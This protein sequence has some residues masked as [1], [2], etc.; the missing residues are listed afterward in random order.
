MS[1]LKRLTE[2]CNN[3]I[4]D[5]R[6]NFLIWSFTNEFDNIHKLISDK[7]VVSRLSNDGWEHFIKICDNRIERS[8]IYSN[9]IA[10][11]VGF[12]FVALSIIATMV[13]NL[14]G[15]KSPWNF[16]SSNEYPLIKTVVVFAFAGLLFLF[17]LL[18][19]YRTQIHGWTAFKEQAIMQQLVAKKNE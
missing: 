1:A 2:N 11:I 15:S 6:N 8:K 4:K 7:F 14:I 16:I 17:L 9:E 3:T 12:I 13:N 18:S 19:H 5:N 10:C